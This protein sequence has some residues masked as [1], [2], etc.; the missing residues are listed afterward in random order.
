MRP[1]QHEDLRDTNAA[2]GETILWAIGADEKQGL[3]T[4]ANYQDLA[5]WFPQVKACF[6]IE[7]PALQDLNVLYKGRTVAALCF[8]SSRFPYVVKNPILNAQKQCSIAQAPTSI[9]KIC[10]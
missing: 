8:D 9:A 10:T 2:R 7:V 1:K 5:N 6:E 4:G 3:I